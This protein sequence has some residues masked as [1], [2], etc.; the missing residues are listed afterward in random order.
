MITI[1]ANQARPTTVDR[2]NPAGR[3]ESDALTMLDHS[4]ALRT[5][6]A[7]DAAT[8]RHARERT[9]NTSVAC[10]G[11][12]LHTGRPATMTLMPAPA[13][14]GIVFER[15]D[16]DGADR[17]IP[18]LW[19][20]VV[21]TGHCTMI[22]NAAGA[23]VSTIEHLM[24]ALAG[25]GVD[26]LLVRIDGPEVPIM[27]GSAAP[28]LF[29]MECAGLC[30]QESVRMALAITRPVVIEHGARRA[31]ITPADH[32]EIDV[33]IDF[34]SAAVT[35]Q[36]CALTVTEGAFKSEVSRARTFGFLHEVDGMRA[37]GLALGGS[38]DNAVVV[39][40]DRVL[41][42]GGLRYPD[43]FARHK[44]LDCVGDLYLAGAPLLG[45]FVGSRTGHAFN[46]RLLRAVFADR[47]N[48]DLVPLPLAGAAA[49][50]ARLQ[51][52]DEGIAFDRVAATA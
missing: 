25:L 6:S 47:R 33:E 48:W 45:R 7:R 24:A 2:A 16:F 13:G 29:L 12:G 42:D 15:T 23:T 43:E 9:L 19:H 5:I 14:H 49:R 28:L 37:A 22:G 40:G 44:A 46:N 52:A 20:A 39:S 30:E 34:D 11:I 26:N 4:S 38:L 1:R 51:A 50:P 36:R 31:E 10:T 18:A 21:N 32:W 3:Y 17:F 35:R 8:P 41:N 27:D